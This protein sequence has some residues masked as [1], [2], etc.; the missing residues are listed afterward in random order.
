MRKR[1]ESGDALVARVYEVQG[2]K[3]VRPFQV[4][5]FPVDKLLEVGVYIK[6]ALV[7][8]VFDVYQFRIA[9]VA[10]VLEVSPRSSDGG[11]RR[12]ILCIFEIP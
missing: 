2:F 3:F 4:F 5:K 7:A 9:L 1:W 6:I 12:L 8:R 10:R 11:T